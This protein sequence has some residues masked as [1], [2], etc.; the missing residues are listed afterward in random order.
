MLAAD[1]DFEFGQHLASDFIF[2]QHP[3]NRIM[4][5]LF[6]F[7]FHAVGCRFGSQTRVA[8]VPSVNFLVGFTG[9]K[10]DFFAVRQNHEIARVHVGCISRLVFAHQHHGDIR[11]DAT[12]DLVGSIDNP[13][14]FVECVILSVVRF[15]TWHREFSANR[16]G[17]EL[18]FKFGITQFIGFFRFLQ[19]STGRE[20]CIF[21]C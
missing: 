5:D 21:R 20:S 1:V 2:G 10:F 9:R 7:A 15:R 18:S 4:H 17:G 3:A 8:G 14:L 16:I 6:W 11:G 13:P 19:G 12:D